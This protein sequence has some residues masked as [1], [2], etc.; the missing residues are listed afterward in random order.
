MNPEELAKLTEKA[1]WIA[2]YYLERDCSCEE[3]R[4]CKV[5][6]LSDEILTALKSAYSKGQEEMKHR[7]SKLANNHYEDHC[8]EDCPCDHWREEVAKVIE[9]LEVL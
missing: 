8:C 9:G 5:C 3:D 1:K 7:A 6:A 4:K 2:E